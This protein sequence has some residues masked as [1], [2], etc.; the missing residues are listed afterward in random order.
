M[1]PLPADLELQAHLSALEFQGF[2]KVDGAIP[3]PLLSRVQSA[4][5]RMIAGATPGRLGFGS[6]LHKQRACVIAP[7]G[8]IEAAQPYEHHTALLEL[9]ELPKPMAVVEALLGQRIATLRHVHGSRV[10]HRAA[11]TAHLFYSTNAH[12]LPPGVDCDLRWHADGDLLRYTWLIE[13]LPPD[14]GGTLFLPGT[15]RAQLPP[16]KPT[17]GAQVP[18][19]VNNKSRHEDSREWRPRELP[20]AV[21]ISGTAGDCFINFTSCWHSRGINSAETP[22][23]L[24]WQVIGSDGNELPGLYTKLR[25]GKPLL[26]P[27]AAL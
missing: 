12:V 26:G 11:G 9:L 4:F 18:G 23:C 25:S 24:I 16:D 6:A 5:R 21:P 10:T 3:E 19:W 20:N 8:V 13:D 17:P 27:Q 1:E 2:T 7:D 15:H 22:R 14:G